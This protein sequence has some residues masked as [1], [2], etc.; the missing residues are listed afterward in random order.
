MHFADEADGHVAADRAAIA[1]YAAE[2]GLSS[3]L[4]ARRTRARLTQREQ[5][6]NLC[7][8]DGPGKGVVGSRGELFGDHPVQGSGHAEHLGGLALAPDTVPC[9][10]K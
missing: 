8:V 10:A 4:P 6:T 1:G 3:T 9:H 2:Q 7:L 5:C